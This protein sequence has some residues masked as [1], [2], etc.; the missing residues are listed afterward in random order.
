MLGFLKAVF[1]SATTLVLVVALAAVGL[2]ILLIGKALWPALLGLLVCFLV[3]L[4]IQE[5]WRDRQKRRTP[6][7]D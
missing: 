5:W 2:L 7:H 4:V 3:Y 1:W 6:P